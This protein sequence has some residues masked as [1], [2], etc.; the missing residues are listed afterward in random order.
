MSVQ[1][2]W[3]GA[4]RGV[5]ISALLLMAAA[6]GAQAPESESESESSGLEE[7]VVTA[8]FRRQN[9]QDTPL[10]ITAVS[11]EMLEAR[12][13]TGLAEVANQAPNVTLKSNS[14]AYGPS[15]AANIRG[16]GQFD[17]H[18]A[19]E[20]GVGIYVDD[21]YY[22]T[23]TGSILDL[24]DLERVELLRGPQGTLAGKNSIG[25][26]VK[27]Y[28]RRPTGDGPSSVAVT[29]GSRDRVDVRASAEF[30]LTDKVFARVAG[31]S[32]SQDGYVDVLDYGCVNP[33]SGVP[34]VRPVGDCLVSK[35]GGVDYQ[36]MRGQL[37]IAPADTFEVNLIGDF[38]RDDRPIAG[39]VLTFANYT[40]PGDINPFNVPLAFDSRF[41]CGRFCNYSTYVSPPDAPYLESRIPGRVDFESWGVSGQVDWTLANSLQLVSI[42]AW[43]E[44]TSIFSNEDDLSPMTH[45]LGGPNSLDF[46]AFSQELRLNGSFGANNL[47]EYTVGGFYMDQEAFYSAAQDL[48]Y[49]P[50]GLVFVSGDPVPADTKALFVHATWNATSKLSV[51]GGARYTEE[52]KDYTFKRVDRTGQ[53][54][55]GNLGALNGVTGLYEGDTVDYRASVQYR[56]VDD[57]M[58]YLQYSTGFKG[59]G[60]NPRPFVVQQVQPFGPE[61]LDTYELGFK[62]DVFDRKVRL[63]L[64]LF[65]SEY[66]D[67][68]LTLNSCPQFN[69]PGLPPGVAFPCGMPANVGTAEIRGAEL[70]ANLRLIDGLLIDSAVSYLDFE[71]THIDPLAGGPTNPAGVQPW[72]ISPYT[73]ELKWSA[74]IQYEIPLGSAGFLIPRIDV[75]FQDDV[76]TTAINTPR[77]LIDSYTVANA[78][79]TWRDTKQEWEGSLEVTNLTDE[80]YYT[81]MFELAA[82]AAV[83]NAQPARPREWALTI[84]R[85][86]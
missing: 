47:I 51:T 14:A 26:A 58:T 67:I 20:P 21:V 82:A 6:V 23:L 37:R 83:A 70:E 78:R 28:S 65:H 66:D 12:S 46:E 68:Q 79:L 36:A 38:T 61:T 60:I 18:P 9:L 31:V 71:Y 49:V 48:R 59:G 10:A 3:S 85:R 35:Q 69:P 56:W 64:A 55:A 75:A 50:G 52:G 39:T 34:S 80:Y 27:L 5:A 7:V 16:V 25:G 19:L 42:T 45:S 74:G 30:G 44:Y 17:F 41:I 63:N 32:K 76:Y 53:P 77:T 40:G 84:R 62:A 43:R 72:M 22:S 2:A 13:Q 33:S 29:Y 4:G 86:F 24:L 73:P 54:L 81:T 57:F 15:L 8:Q 11:A 1:G